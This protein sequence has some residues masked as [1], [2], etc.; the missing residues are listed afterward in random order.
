MPDL[1]MQSAL[2]YCALMQYR[3]I[4]TLGRKGK[5]STVVI[6]FPENAFHH[7]AGF[8]KASFAALRN[9]SKSLRIILDGTVTAADFAVAGYSFEDRW[10]GLCHLQEMLESNQTVF[11]YRGRERADSRI[12]ADYLIQDALTVFFVAENHPASI[13][14]QKGQHYELNCPRFTTLQIIR[15][16]VATGVQTE[17]YRAAAYKTEQ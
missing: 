17:V 3:Y 9:R 11:R 12:T 5:A 6:D 14:G 8:H 1:L 4:F 15:E 16:D 2:A 7:L 13:F 10:A